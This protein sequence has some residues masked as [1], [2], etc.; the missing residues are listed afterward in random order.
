MFKIFISRSEQIEISAVNRKT[1]I[2]KQ[3]L[4]RKQSSSTCQNN[5]VQI[6]DFK[7]QISL[8]S[9][10]M[11]LRRTMTIAEPEDNTCAEENVHD[12]SRSKSE[13]VSSQFVPKYQ[14]GKTIIRLLVQTFFQLTRSSSRFWN[15]AIS[16]KASNRKFEKSA[17]RFSTILRHRV[18]SNSAF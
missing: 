8:V 17:G 3:G 10:K 14:S 1:F 2:D 9:T 4:R 18:E 15:K 16:P 12:I 7:S 13:S 11:H 6:N 5:Y